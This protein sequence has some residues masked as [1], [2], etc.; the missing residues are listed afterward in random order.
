MDPQQRWLLE[1]AWEAMEDGGTRPETLR[2]SNTGCFV[3]IA[4]NE[5]GSIQISG[6]RDIDVHTNSGGT[7][8][9]ASNRISYL[10]D[11]KGPSASVDTACSSALVAV[12]LAC[13]SIWSGD[14]DLALAGGVNALLM[15]DASIG[16]SKASMLSPSGQCFAFDA[17]ANGY[18]RGEGAGMLLIKPL[19]K[20]QEDGDRIYALIRAAGG[21]PGRQ[22]VL[23]DRPGRGHP[24]RDAPHRLPRGRLPAF[25][26]LLHGGARHR[27]AGRRP[28]RDAR[29]R[30]GAVRGAPRR[31]DLRHR[32]GEVQHRPPR[33][34]LG[35]RRPHQG[36]DGAAQ[37]A[38]P[39]Q[40]QLRDA[41]PEHPVRR[42]QIARPHQARAS[43]A[44]G[45]SAAGHRGQLLRLRRHQLAHRARGGAAAGQASG[46]D[47]QGGAPIHPSAVRQ[48]RGAAQGVRRQVPRFPQRLRSPAGRHLF[49]RRDP[50]GAPGGA[51]RRHRQ[52]PARAA[53]AVEEE[54]QRSPAP[55]GLCRRSPDGDQPGHHLRLHRPGRAVVGHGA[56]AA[57]ARAD[58]P[59]HDRAHR[60]RDPQ[61]RG[62]VAG[63]GDDPWRGRL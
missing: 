23:D 25:A 38:D 54:L 21:K 24:G 48:H 6:E 35:S 61:A 4:S 13:K 2:G 60:P 20:A 43:A 16:F 51:H 63:R 58:L 57:R 5:Y 28:H 56:A 59:R 12:N 3:G 37:V 17:R 41:Q 62:L 45:R 47:G 15:P 49:Q 9:I 31:R 32:L 7:L 8:S 18:V 52:R 40:P 11:F 36:G 29:A 42:S 46:T 34:R 53:L 27:H 33:V 10:F 39:G 22:H 50:Q 26:R 19:A 55:G 14:S 1:C 44:P 30:Q